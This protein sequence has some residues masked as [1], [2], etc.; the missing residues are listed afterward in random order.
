MDKI[1]LYE[2]TLAST[3]TGTTAFYVAKYDQL[4]IQ[5]PAVVGVF[6]S[7]VVRIN[8]LG[9]A[10][11]TDTPVQMNY[12]DYVNKTPASSVITVSTA[13]I[14]EFPYPG[15]MNYIRVSFDI[16]CSQATSFK[17]ITPKTT[18]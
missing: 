15:A 9:A 1:Q 4:M 2:Q 11:S 17:F 16:P 6:S 8:L 5:V 7:G 14:Y 13:G 3:A 18:Y 10:K 12:Y